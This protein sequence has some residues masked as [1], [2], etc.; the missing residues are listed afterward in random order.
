MT[1]TLP[2][3][4]VVRDGRVTD[5]NAAFYERDGYLLAPDLLSPA[6]VASVRSEAAAILRGERGGVEGLLNP[7]PDASDDAVI[8]RYN[9]IHFP[10]KISDTLRQFVTHPAIAGVLT[11][12]VGPN[13][14]CMQSMLFTKGPGKPGQ[15][16]HQDEYFIPTRDRSLTGVW[17][18]V[19]DADED[20][21][22]LWVVP[23]SHRDGVI[24]R[25]VDYDGDQ[26]GDADTI[27]LTDAEEAAAVPVP[28]P[29]GGVLFFDG[30]LLH[31]SNRNTT[32]SRTRVA[33]VH[34]VMSAESMLPWDNG[35]RTAPTNDNRDIVLVAGEDPHA[36]K[37]TADLLAP[38]LRPDRMVHDDQH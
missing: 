38:F 36:W 10:H 23:G 20:N 21:G 13:V 6:E 7:D 15:S 14:K 24:R 33:L 1:D 11:R 8:A 4:A 26:F 34:H 3:D 16:W 5:A 12:V 29:S 25:R 28:V 31:A 35:G 37:G 19:D 30:H 32:S 27:G 17:I 22:C 9:A 2:A 18:A